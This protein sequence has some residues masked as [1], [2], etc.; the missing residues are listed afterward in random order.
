MGRGSDLR[1]F[2][3]VG[4]QMG[5]WERGAHSRPHSLHP[6]ARTPWAPGA[7]LRPSLVTTRPTPTAE[8]R[9]GYTSAL[10]AE[11][12]GHALPTGCP[13]GSCVLGAKDGVTKMV[14]VFICCLLSADLSEAIALNAA[15]SL[16]QFLQG[17]VGVHLQLS[18]S[19]RNS[20]TSVTSELRELASL[21]VPGLP[22]TS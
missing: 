20:G 10:R 4:A 6:L 18:T 11:C 21:S 16:I 3:Q 9:V 8:G 12:Q 17:G 13:G 14:S 2:L 1:L 22:V 15:V 19:A 5:V 7:M